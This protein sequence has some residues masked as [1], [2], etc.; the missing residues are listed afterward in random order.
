MSSV[1]GSR[2]SHLLVESLTDGRPANFPKAGATLQPRQLHL[3]K[4][5]SQLGT[6]GAAQS[7]AGRGADVGMH[8]WD[9]RCSSSRQTGGA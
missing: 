9:G 8:I 4:N 6:F 1:A 7:F 3:T 2:Q 5:F